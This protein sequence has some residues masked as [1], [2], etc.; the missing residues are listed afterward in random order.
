M[1]V[2]AHLEL[3]KHLVSDLST[4]TASQSGSYFDH[5]A[6]CANCGVCALE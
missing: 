5:I 1:W 4:S 2:P 3:C 6:Y